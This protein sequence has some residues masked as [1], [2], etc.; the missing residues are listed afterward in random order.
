VVFRPI[1]WIAAAFAAGIAC[2][3]AY[4]IPV[5]AW[6]LA[7]LALLAAAGLLLAFR[8]S[9]AV[10]LLCAVVCTGAILYVHEA[11]PPLD[12]PLLN[13]DRQH[14][15]MT[16]VVTRPPQLRPRRMRLV[17]APETV[18]G[19]AGP[20]R[21]P[22]GRVQVV[23]RGHHKVRYGDRVQVVGRLLRPP[24][25]GNPGEF[26]YRDHLAAEGIKALLAPG[27]SGTFK[28]L[29]HGQGQPLLA[30][31]FAA[32]ERVLAVFAKALPGRPGALLASL[33]LGDDGAIEPQMTQAFKRAGLLHVLVVSGAQVGLVM[34][35]VVWLGRLLRAPPAVIAALSG[36]AV[37]GFALMAGWVPS[38]ARAA[39]MAVAA[40]VAMAWARSY[41]ATAALSLASLILLSSSP[42]LLF[43]PG[44]QLSFVATWA[45]LYVAPVLQKR[46][47][48]S[49]ALRTLVSMTIAAQVAVVPVLAFHFQQ[50]SLTG[51][52][53]N[54]LVVPVVAV[55]VPAGF[56]IS[57][58]GLI[59]PWAAGIAAWPLRPLLDLVAYLAHLFSTLPGAAVPI[60]PPGLPAV[61]IFFLLI[62]VVVEWLRGRL[63][64]RPESVLAAGT[65][66]LAVVLW[67][68]VAT[69]GPS[70]LTITAL[71]VGQGDALVIRG[72]SGQTLLIDGGGHLEGQHSHRMDY[73]VGE[74]RVVPALRRMRIHRIDVVV[75][76]H[77]HEDHV[78]GL[79]AV[80]KNFSVGLVLDSGL[81]HP[82]PS[83]A[84]F[85]QL[86]D[87]RG[88]PYVLVRRGMRLDLGDRVGMI[89]LLPQEPLIRGSGSDPN[90]NSVVARL[91]YGSVAALFTGDMEAL[92]EFQLLDL[93]DDVRSAVLKVAHHGSDTGTT[94]AF[95]DAV[96]PVVAVISVGT[97][98]PFGHPDPDTLAV[99]EER[100]ASVYR[101]DEHGAVIIET[102][103]R[104]VRVRTIRH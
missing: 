61:A 59:A 41:D 27:R 40:A 65:C 53:A 90:H 25:A 4:Q 74:Q 16:G 19:H 20:I 81:A 70:L 68:R 45:L 36:G 89:V 5:D 14:V 67:S 31:V 3:R 21:R 83:Y 34:A 76:T 86:I 73:D 102:D 98:N 26:S 47:P 54:L 17:V 80:L 91:T 92:N 51:F 29:E 100:G 55:L 43:D 1:A 104:R 32:R 71:D 94:E 97:L 85:R 101:T 57:V 58:I 18:T 62:T 28:L 22:R 103:G 72:P 69:A 63:R 75:L 8:L 87:A 77:P 30:A 88:I 44:F 82:S 24:E 79:I 84:R 12:D 9:A 56:M 60:Y 2:A 42:L 23:L 33:L 46:V 13:L 10:P 64:L 48:G 37:V 99:L 52:I 93:G 38:V 11:R 50:V 66:A 95:V 7:G 49:S 35:S 15:V 6:V 96:R 39:I 78:G